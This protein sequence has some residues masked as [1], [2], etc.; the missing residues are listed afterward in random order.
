MKNSSEEEEEEDVKY[1]GDDDILITFS[2]HKVVPHNLE[3]KEEM[4]TIQHSYDQVE[5]FGKP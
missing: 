2:A 5:Y 3:V 4:R 1:E